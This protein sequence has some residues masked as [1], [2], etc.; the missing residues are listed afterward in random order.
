MDTVHVCG[1]GARLIHLRSFS[2]FFCPLYVGH[3]TL[4]VR[5]E[6]TSKGKGTQPKYYD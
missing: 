1:L 3:V 4:G 6:R 2:M 5:E